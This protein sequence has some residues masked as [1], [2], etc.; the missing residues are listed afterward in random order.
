MGGVTMAETNKLKEKSG[1][2]KGVLKA[3]KV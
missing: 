1:N 2:F 3:L